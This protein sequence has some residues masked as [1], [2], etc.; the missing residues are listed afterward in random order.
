MG[1]KRDYGGSEDS[2]D[3]CFGG[4]GQAYLLRTEDGRPRLLRPTAESTGEEP[5]PVLRA[6]LVWQLEVPQMQ[7]R[8]EILTQN[9]PNCGEFP[10]NSGQFSSEKLAFL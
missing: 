5:A 8:S 10:A 3:A 6:D 1:K 9:E 4:L 7:W 2:P